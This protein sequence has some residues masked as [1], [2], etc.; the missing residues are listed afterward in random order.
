MIGKWLTCVG[1]FLSV[2]GTILTLWT[3]CSTDTKFAGTWGELGA[4]HENFPKEKRR[5][6]FGLFVIALGGVLQIIGQLI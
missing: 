1:I 3:T 2:F 4:R 5:V 6:I